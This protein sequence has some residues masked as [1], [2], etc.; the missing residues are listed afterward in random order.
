MH[1]PAPDLVFQALL[2][3]LGEVVSLRFLPFGFGTHC[4]CW[5]GLRCVIDVAKKRREEEGRVGCRWWSEEEV[6]EG[7]RG[8]DLTTN[9]QRMMRA[10]E[11]A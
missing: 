8:K 7:G 11:S 5:R 10:M 3:Y 1:A 2:L 6:E 9:G 4:C